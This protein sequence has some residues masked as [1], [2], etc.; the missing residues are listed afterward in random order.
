M[1]NDRHTQLL[2]QLMRSTGWQT[3]GEL[4]DA[5]GVTSRSIRTYIAAVKAKADPL[6]VIE[7]GPD[8][9]R[10]DREA[11]AAYVSA[12]ETVSD[13][14]TPRERLH[15]L[16]RLLVD[17]E[18]G[19]DVFE[20][21]SALF[22]S[23]ST[24]ETDLS[25]VRAL[26]ADTQLELKR[27]GSRV[28]LQGSELARRRLL[29]RL[30]RDET[31]HGMAELD[32]IQRAF[33]SESLGSFKT[34]LIDALQSSGY[35]INDYG[36][37]NVLL[38][39]AIAADRAGRSQPVEAA[40][41]ETGADAELRDVVRRLS[42]TH[43]AEPLG[44]A[45]VGYIAYLLSTRAVAPRPD[46]DASVASEYFTPEE[47]ATVRAIAERAS[48]EYLVDLTDVDFLTRLT[49]H[50]SNLLERAEDQS[51][52]RNP[53]TKSIK[54]AYPMIYELAVFL[55]SGLHDARGIVVN[56]D[57]IAYI[58]MHI[59]AH[60]QQQT[61][62]DELATC[63]LVCPNYYDLQAML[64]D[65]VVQALGDALTVTRVVTRT[66]VPWSRLDADLIL[67]TIEPPVPAENIVHIQPF[68]SPADVDKVRAALSRTR[69]LARRA[70]IRDELLRYLD[71]SLF[72]RDINAQGEEAVIRVLG[73]RMLQQGVI[74]AGYIE[75][76]IE[77]E[78]MSSTAFTDT[79]A[80][81]HAM[82]MTA[83]RTSIAIAVNER[84]MPWGDGRVNVV[85]LIAF[86]AEGRAQFQEVF[87]QFVEVFSERD[88]VASIIRSG[89]TFSTFIDELVRTMDS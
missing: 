17:D 78:R 2:T 24:L 61:R 40:G 85:A 22:I 52:S 56:D 76:A 68:L 65:R 79:L 34:D 63:V 57:E 66:D 13:E 72:V 54:T 5:L 88:D 60:L 12:A 6:P 84:S 71:E 83:R 46:A 19:F 37:D 58:A 23:D 1:S 50:V 59:G 49:V 33:E 51:Y 45:D 10:L 20:T 44:E 82:E 7:S 35:Y 86:S 8:G 38:H 70:S 25:R 87:D 73:E 74:D 77:R 16:V 3:A 14:G 15:R 81:P 18:N 41:R 47:F 55:A 11:Y 9:Y 29:S 62:R 80:V 36:M 21:A 75:G 31:T 53:L 64:A 28:V 30:F 27:T 67:T 43:F 26:L 89:R 32:A 39:I 48:D 4:A 69:R 42:R